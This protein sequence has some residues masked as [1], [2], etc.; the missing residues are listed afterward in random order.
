MAAPKSPSSPLLTDLSAELH[1]TC[2]VCGARVL[3]A[4]ASS[5]FPP[6]RLLF[7]GRF[8]GRPHGFSQVNV[9]RTLA[10]LGVKKR[11]FFLPWVAYNYCTF[12]IYIS[13]PPNRHS[14]LPSYPVC[15]PTCALRYVSPNVQLTNTSVLSLHSETINN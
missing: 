12:S 7:G 8:F 11:F 4:Q 9:P 5:S 15:A 13:R 2:A 14:C 3:R 10:P 1:P 6:K